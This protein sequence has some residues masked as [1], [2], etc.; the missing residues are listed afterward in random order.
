MKISIAQISS[1][2]GDIQKNI[3]KHIVFV[4]EA[5]DNKA[6]LICFP[7]LSITGYEPE[8]AKKLATTKDDV[9]FDIFQTLSNENNL[10]ICIGVPTFD[11]NGRILIS[12][13]I[14]QPLK[15][16]RIYSKQ[17]LHSD[18]KPFFAEGNE[19]IIIECKGKRIAPAICYES[20]LQDH[21][22]NAKTMGIDIY[23]ASVAKPEKNIQKAYS[24]FSN[25]AKEN[26]I[27]VLMVNSVG[28]SDN[29]M[30]YGSSAVWNNE[31]TLVKRLDSSLENNLIYEF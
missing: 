3:E 19:Q 7:E 4:K 27:P 15:E 26:S 6:D 31:G 18:E 2:K 14:F 9:G 21:F 25:L 8:L 24:Y 22:D 13:L 11:S 10:T 16:I 28:Y 5:I 1:F 23:L 17:H 30:A 20:L 12:M 29:F